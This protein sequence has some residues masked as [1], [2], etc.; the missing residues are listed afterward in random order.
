MVAERRSVVA[1]GGGEGKSSRKEGRTQRG[2]RKR[3]S[4]DAG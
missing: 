1:W 3:G 2:L 4:G